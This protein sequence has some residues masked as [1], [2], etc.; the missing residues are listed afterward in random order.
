[1]TTK[2]AACIVILMTIFFFLQHKLF[3]KLFDEKHPNEEVDTP[4]LFSWP[5]NEEI[6]QKVA[7]APPF[8]IVPL[9]SPDQYRDS[10]SDTVFESDSDLESD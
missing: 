4:V 1:M 6:N 8:K 9:Y 5:K 10:N 2:E 7:I 3:H